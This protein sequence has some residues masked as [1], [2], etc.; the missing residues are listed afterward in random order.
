[1]PPY[2]RYTIK[3]AL[4]CGNLKLFTTAPCI[5]TGEQ[6]HTQQFASKR[7]FMTLHFCNT[8]YLQ[9]GDGEYRQNDVAVT[10]CIGCQEDPACRTPGR[11]EAPVDWHLKWLIAK[12][13]GQ[14]HNRLALMKM[15]AVSYSI[16]ATFS[17]KCRLA[18]S[19]FFRDSLHNSPVWNPFIE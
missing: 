3:S 5:S 11:M 19:K 14:W 8:E 7:E 13:G 16:A 17:L 9:R 12:Q 18:M 15:A 6:S 10:P 2:W 1:M 4:T